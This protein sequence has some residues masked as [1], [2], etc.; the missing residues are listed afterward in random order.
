MVI[1]DPSK[2]SKTLPEAS[3]DKLSPGVIA[4]YIACILI[5]GTTWNAV[6][7]CV[8][9]GGFE[10]YS[11]AAARFAFAAAFLAGMWMLGI[12]KA[13][14]TT[15]SAT[16]WISFTGFLGVL[17]LALVY[18]AHQWVS[19]G[20]AAILATTSP[21]MMALLATA[22]RAEKVSFNSLVGAF[23][24]V[25]GIAILFGDRLHISNDQATGVILVL[26]S[27]FLNAISGVI[28]KK[29][30]SNENPFV[31]VA[32]FAAISLPC[33]C[34]LSMGCE[35]VDLQALSPVTIGAAA[36]LGVMGSV[37]SFACYFY[38]LKRLKLM[39]LSSMVFF[40]PIIALIVDSFIEKSVTLTGASY[41]GIGVIMTGVAIGV[42]LKPLQD[43][44][45]RRRAL[46]LTALHDHVVKPDGPRELSCEACSK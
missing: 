6:R 32:L 21:L 46:S 26:L 17:S 5:W 28:L 24:S 13:K 11:A 40:P 43:R 38:L 42:V 33:F 8:L 14:P 35:K 25:C 12:L 39:T 34:A 10:P 20:L 1:R 37:I 36:Y 9:P 29:K 2:I 27:V 3:E 4:A 22:T 19:G 31:F 45:L 15:L 7:L 41:A 23:V 16:L 18:T 30:A 44:L